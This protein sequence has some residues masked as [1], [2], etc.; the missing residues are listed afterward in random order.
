MLDSFRNAITRA[1]GRDSIL[2][3]D[4]RGETLILDRFYHTL[5]QLT[6][7]INLLRLSRLKMAVEYPFLG[8]PHTDILGEGYH[9]GDLVHI[10]VAARTVV[11]LQQGHHRGVPPA[12]DTILPAVF[13]IE[14]DA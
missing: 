13:R 5:A 2:A 9:F 6:D 12:E 14:I 10:Q 4:R 8:M 1:H 11:I 3:V 7:T